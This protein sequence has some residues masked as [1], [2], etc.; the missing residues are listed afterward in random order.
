MNI[1]LEA[2]GP[3]Q[4][5]CLLRVVRISIS[6]EIYSHLCFSRG[7]GGR[8]LAPTPSGCVHDTVN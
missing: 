1:P 6:K 4:S 7:G 2:I 8:P 3:K 5:N